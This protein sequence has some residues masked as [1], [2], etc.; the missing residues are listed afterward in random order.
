MEVLAISL[1]FVT[2]TLAGCVLAFML[3]TRAVQGDDRYIAR[4][5]RDSERRSQ[6]AWVGPP[7]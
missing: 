6:P 1:V 4:A 3:V 2:I 5:E 7:G